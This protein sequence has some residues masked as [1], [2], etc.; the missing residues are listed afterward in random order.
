MYL[1]PILLT[2]IGP[3]PLLHTSTVT[4]TILLTAIGSLSILLTAFLLSAIL[5]TAIG[6]L[7]LLLTAIGLLHAL[8]TS[9][10]LLAYVAEAWQAEPFTEEEAVC[11]WS[12]STS[13]VSDLCRTFCPVFEALYIAW[14]GIVTVIATCSETVISIFHIFQSSSAIKISLLSKYGRIKEW[15]WTNEGILPA[16]W[17]RV[18]CQTFHALVLVNFI[19]RCD[20][21]WASTDHL[22]SQNKYPG[23]PAF[24]L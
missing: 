4:L 3:L 15:Q 9:V 23:R 16:R 24:Y 10:F 2:I 13:H 6:L 1:S 7:P 18:K 8:L 17:I 22:N 19:H 12:E 5:F 21:S 20:T 14:W 11:R